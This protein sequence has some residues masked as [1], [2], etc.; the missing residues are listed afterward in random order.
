MSLFLARRV[1]QLCIPR[2]ASK[3]I[4]R[5]HEAHVFPSRLT[6]C[7]SEAVEEHLASNATVVEQGE[8]LPRVDH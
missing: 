7:F 4:V 5:N 1:Q 2:N 6:C 8:H 3:A